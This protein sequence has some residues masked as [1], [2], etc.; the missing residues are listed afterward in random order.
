MKLG[1]YINGWV[2]GA[3]LL[4]VA[5]IVPASLKSSA[6]VATCVICGIW[7]VIYQFVKKPIMYESLAL[8]GLYVLEFLAM[9]FAKGLMDSSPMM[10]PLIF[11]ILFVAV[12]TGLFFFIKAQGGNIVEDD[13]EEDDDDE[14]YDDDDEDDEE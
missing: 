14:Y 5:L 4:I 2:N 9:T 1:S 13:D 11:G 12:F 6:M 10:L 3:L 8:F 7:M